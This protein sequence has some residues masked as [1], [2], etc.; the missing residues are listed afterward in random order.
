MQILQV[1]LTSLIA[2][3]ILFLITRFLGFKQVSQLTM[4]DY[5]IGISMGSIA[6][7]MAIELENPEHSIVAMLVFG[8][9]A[10]L[11]TLI[12]RKSG[13]LRKKIN[14]TTHIVYDKGVIYR[15]NLKKSKIDLSEFLSM[16]RTQGYFNL[17]DIQTAVFEDNGSLSIL[18]SC[19]TRPSRPDDF[20]L[21]PKQNYVKTNIIMD[22]KLCRNNLELTG[23]TEKWVENQIYKQGY[24]CVD[25]ILLATLENNS[26]ELVLYPME[27]ETDTSDRFQ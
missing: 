20:G 6:A 24:S 15:E 5:V 25:D 4:F 16:C 18:P 19:K 11:V 21:N 14:G 26:N 17:K 23:K 22:G 8:L 3:I 2:V 9:V 27:T 10:I 1:A 12:T 13:K 7:D